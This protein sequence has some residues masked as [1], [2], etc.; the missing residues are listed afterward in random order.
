MSGN[1]K[2]ISINPDFFKLGSRKGGRSATVSKNTARKDKQ[3]KLR[4]KTL[5]PNSVRKKLLNRIRDYQKQQ[6]KLQNEMVEQYSSEISVDDIEKND[7]DDALDVLQKIIKQKKKERTQKN[8]QGFNSNSIQIVGSQAPST[9]QAIP[10]NT[11][12]NSQQTP[13]TQIQHQPQ[14][15]IGGY[16]NKTLKKTSVKEAPPFGCLKNGKKPTYRAYMKSVK[17]STPAPSLKP[18]NPLIKIEDLPKSTSNVTQATHITERK[19]KL[20]T[21]KNKYKINQQGGTPETVARQNLVKSKLMKL[22]LPTTKQKR[23][24][25]KTIKRTYKL[26]KQKGK[27]NVDVLIKNNETRKKVNSAIR[28]LKK[29]PLYDVNKFL[30]EKNFIKTGSS[31]PENVKRAIFNNSMLAGDINN[32]NSNVMIHNYMADDAN[33]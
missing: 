7:F 31:A 17:Q 4:N 12:H 33:S 21:I 9:Q 11:L 32:T 20:D 13:Q 25:V 30:K 15:H 23:W 28:A 2:K 26:G 10:Q 16:V 27:R 14:T 22:N 8:R 5:K 24:R 19:S 1:S 18:R 3:R 6:Q 29:T